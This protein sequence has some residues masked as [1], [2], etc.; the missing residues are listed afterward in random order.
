MKGVPR[1]PGS[2][3]A[4]ARIGADETGMAAA[5]LMFG[6]PSASGLTLALAR[7]VRDLIEVLAGVGWLARTG[8]QS[9]S[10]RPRLAFAL[11]NWR[12]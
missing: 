6:L 2:P 5:F 4:P 3:W 1:R 10:R 11:P 9:I 8:R 7:R 12:A